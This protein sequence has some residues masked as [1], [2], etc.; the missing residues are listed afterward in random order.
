ML[1]HRVMDIVIKERES[2][3]KAGDLVKV[4]DWGKGYSTN[5]DWFADNLLELKPLWLVKY[6]YGNSSNYDYRR[7]TDNGIY[8]VLYSDGNMILITGNISPDTIYN[9]YLIST[10]GVKNAGNQGMIL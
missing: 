10:D 4:T 6:A 9:V 7:T 8:R 5:T 1:R 2:M 3:I